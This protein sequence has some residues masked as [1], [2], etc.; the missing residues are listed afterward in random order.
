[1]MTAGN[2]FERGLVMSTTQSVADSLETLLERWRCGDQTAATAIFNRYRDRIVELARRRIGPKL[3]SRVDPEDV[4]ISVIDTVLRRARDGRYVVD[5]NGSLWKLFRK[6]TENKIRRYAEY[7]NAGIRNRKA[8][9]EWPIA[10]LP[11]DA[12]P[13][14]EAVILADELER[15]RS[16]LKPESFEIFQLLLQG[17][18]IREIAEQLNCSQHT[19]RSRVKQIQ[20]L[21]ANWAE[22]DPPKESHE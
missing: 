17:R 6:V 21:L 3:G 11:D 10:D 4:M 8:E 13:P 12:P 7:V 2:A 19:V 14:E 16:R 18:S 1:M 9:E 5:T 20:E 15:I 22:V